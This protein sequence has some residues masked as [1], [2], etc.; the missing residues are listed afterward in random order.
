[1][2]KAL[3]ALFSA[4]LISLGVAGCSTSS[5]LV[6][7]AVEYSSGPNARTKADTEILAFRFG[8]PG[9]GGFARDAAT[10]EFANGYIPQRG[11]V[12]GYQKVQTSVWVKWK[13]L[14]D[15]RIHEA[16]AE[17]DNKLPR[18]MTNCEIFFTTYSNKLTVYLVTAERG[19]SLTDPD[20][21]PI[22]ADQF[23]TI[24][25]FESTN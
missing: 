5:S 4:I 19:N 14:S 18:D 2:K 7:Y 24:R 13:T 9:D 12:D 1:M 8:R 22:K 23:K 15:G 6:L 25:L 3:I 10:W 17:F 16:T 11:L 20:H 21:M